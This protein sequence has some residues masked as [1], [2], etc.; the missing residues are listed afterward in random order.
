MSGI[1][2]RVVSEDGGE[3]KKYSRYARQRQAKKK[4]AEE[5]QF[6]KRISTAGTFAMI[7]AAG[8]VMG[9]LAGALRGRR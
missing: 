9:A 2:D 8:R 4:K 1:E 6:W 5:R 7:A 3:E